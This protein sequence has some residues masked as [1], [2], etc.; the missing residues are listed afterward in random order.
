MKA[1]LRIIL[2]G[3][4]DQLAEAFEQVAGQLRSS[5]G[6]FEIL[7][8]VTSSTGLSESLREHYA[9]SAGCAASFGFTAMVPFIHSVLE[10]PD[11]PAAMRV[12]R[13]ERL[14]HECL[15]VLLSGR[16]EELKE[17][18][19][20]RQYLDAG[21]DPASR[22]A[23]AVS[24]AFKMA[25]IFEEYSLGRPDWLEAWEAGRLVLQHRGPEFK[26]REM[27]QAALWR[28]LCRDGTLH[29][30]RQVHQ[31]SRSHWRLPR[32]LIVAGP[33]LVA[34]SYREVMVDIS[35]ECHVVW[36]RVDPGSKDEP[37]SSWSEATRSDLD[38]M[39]A[40]GAQVEQL[41]TESLQMPMMAARF[42]AGFHREAESAARH[43]LS[44]VREGVDPKR[45]LVLHPSTGQ[46][47]SLAL[48]QAFLTY[49]IPA[50][51]RGAMSLGGL[52][53]TF[54]ALVGS[55]APRSLM[56]PWLS[57]EDVRSA[58][59]EVPWDD[60]VSIFTRMGLNRRAQK[61]ESDEARATTWE[62]GLDRLLAGLVH[63]AVDTVQ[64]PRGVVAPWHAGALSIEALGALLHM[65]KSLL[66]DLAFMGSWRAPMTLWCGKVMGF[67]RSN[68]KP[69][70]ISE[71]AW[72]RFMV[73]LESLSRLPG[74]FEMGW[75]EFRPFIEELIATH[76]ESV[77]YAAGGV[78]VG[79][80]S[81]LHALPCDALVITGLNEGVFPSAD[82][83]DPLDLR[84]AEPRKGDASR[85]AQELSRLHAFMRSCRKDV[86]MS[87]SDKDETTG[88]QRAPSG[89]LEDLITMEKVVTERAPLF[90]HDESPRLFRRIQVA[91]PQPMIPRSTLRRRNIPLFHIESF[92]WCEAQGLARHVL[93]LRRE[94][95]EESLEAFDPLVPPSFVVEDLLRQA[96]SGSRDAKEASHCLRQLV[97]KAALAGS[98]PP[99]EHQDL[100]LV[101]ADGALQRLE[102]HLEGAVLEARRF[103]E[104]PRGTQGRPALDVGPCLV[105][106][107]VHLVAPHLL[108]QWH[109][110]SGHDKTKSRRRLLRGLL[111]HMMLSA[112]GEESPRTLRVLSGTGKK[113]DIELL[114]VDRELALAWLSSVV[115]DMG[116][117]EP[118]RRVH[119]PAFFDHDRPEEILERLQADGDAGEYNFDFKGPLPEAE[120]LPLPD[121]E[122]VSRILM[123]RYKPLKDLMKVMRP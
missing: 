6:P 85:R 1:G 79:P 24:L 11:G 109:P 40:A 2:A 49:G 58:S 74:S 15:G 113:E 23:R 8:V 69:R 115:T 54:V 18:A 84:S 59:P 117:L 76:F 41:N 102:H 19:P 88:A 90:P 105:T 68:I 33:D 118:V 57:H 9:R 106:G 70:D 64:G 22:S 31:K 95:E 60:V 98:L 20:C 48:H 29:T 96:Q 87:A 107:T 62:G 116:R 45:I 47:P 94:R 67:L 52:L 12:M 101:E 43:V 97:R 13:R 7:P 71:G 114:E 112:S 119:A 61:G 55:D 91:D 73:D 44:R 63:G 46:K 17:L 32:A 110:L 89:W 75:G 50:S 72:K 42:C 51:Q 92:L 10:I 111:E 28:E 56:I 120:I 21:S 93:G 53:R 30:I 38:L 104:A 39:K 77:D 80:L 3:G 5:L 66:D 27:W 100:W 83:G 103:G 99:E 82:E 26:E 35:K 25:G 14:A 34:E 122:E 123:E 81:A 37:R 108:V 16:L 78:R 36:I 121:T 4:G 65:L 86:F